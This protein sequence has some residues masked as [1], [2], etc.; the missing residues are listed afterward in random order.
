M[1]ISKTIG[2][3]LVA[4][5]GLSACNNVD[6]KKTSAG[7][8]YKLFSE[9]K[10]KVLE[11]GNVVE[12]DVIQKV[13]DSVV[14]STYTIGQPQMLPVQAGLARGY[15][16]IGSNVSEI[17]LKAR[18]GDSVYITQ[19]VDSL[20]KQF[21]ELKDN[22]LF[23]PG[24][25]MVTTMKIREVYKTTEEAQAAMNANRIKN[26]ARDEQ[27][28]LDRLKGDTAFNNQMATD[29]KIIE[30]YLASKNIQATKT[31]W[32]A[33]V[34]VINP[35]QAP[36]PAIGQWVTIKYSGKDLAGKEFDK[37]VFPLQLGMGG[38]IRGFEE[39]AKEL[40]KGGVG[41]VFIPSRLAYGP[42][43]APPKIGPNQVLMFDLEIQDVSDKQP[44]PPQQAPAADTGSHEGHNHQ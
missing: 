44:A 10:G 13:K 2:G 28:Q 15:H 3:V 40:G 9:G 27:A 29:S 26:F 8:P 36:K 25:Q 4:A 39:G 35:G 19:S 22:K 6:F 12:F 1:Q 31:R 21:Q 42:A 24:T 37:G 38:V 17:L 33:Y 20:L 14:F 43:G 16:D 23:Q 34:Q 11:P 32:G 7:V 5:L 30:A 41:R 18:K